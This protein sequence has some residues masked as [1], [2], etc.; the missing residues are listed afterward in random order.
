M[1]LIPASYVEKSWRKALAGLEYGDLE[2]IAPNGEVTLVKGAN[3]GP[4][5]RFEI[6]D[7]DV[8]RRILARGDIGLGEEYIA[9]RWNTDNVERLVSLFLLN[10]DHFAEFSDGN[11][12]NRLGF[13][14]H[15]ALLRRN[16]IRGSSRNIEEH[17]DVGNDFYSLWL[18]RS[19]TYSSALF[20]G[21]ADLYRAQ[22][23]KYERILSKFQAAHARVLE[24]GCGWGG[25][26]ERAIAD[27]HRVTGLTIS[28]AQHRFA[29]E[30]LGAN[31]EIR[32][33]DYRRCRGQFD[34]IVSIEMFEAVGENYWPQYFQ[35]IAER[36][37]R[38]GRAVIQTI[39]I[40]DELFE[41]YRRRSDFIRHYVFPGGMLPSLARFRQEAERAGLKFA[42]A[43]GFGK[44]YVRTLRDWLAR[45]QAQEAAIKALGHDQQF[46][47]NWEFYLGICAAAF[48]VGRT[49]VV[50]VELI[51]A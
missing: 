2:F 38:G 6:Q 7:W 28:P 32:L 47:R 42:G 51:N 31:A 18:D 27:G 44:D 39:T 10:L 17:Y 21:A 1:S 14:I 22:Q 46:L 4:A 34:N 50:Q 37:T 35:V 30:R 19:M 8:L 25:F 48:A 41:S 12:I 24:I 43:F 49:D 23:N 11:L 20:D 26:A 3:P 36:L 5:A 15:N 40:R 16:S 29:T 45:M 33:E 13:V 9:G